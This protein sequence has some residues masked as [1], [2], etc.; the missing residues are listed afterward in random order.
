MIWIRRNISIPAM[1]TDIIN[2]SGNLTSK[3]KSAPIATGIYWFM[4]QAGKILYIG[5]SINLRHRLSSYFY[6]TPIKTEPRILKMLGMASNV[7]WK[8]FDSELLALLAEDR[9]IKQALPEYNIRQ[10]EFN[11]YCFLQLSQEDYPAL[12]IVKEPDLPGGQYFGPYRDK[13]LAEDLKQL[14]VKY[15]QFRACIEKNPAKVCVDLEI[16]LCVG[17]CIGKIQKTEYNQIKKMVANFFT[18]SSQEIVIQI[19]QRMN[20]YS[21][22]QNY[23][24]AARAKS[25]LVFCRAF[26]ERQQFLNRFK[27]DILLVTDN[28]VVPADYRFTRGNLD[29]DTIDQNVDI[30]FIH[31]RGNIVYNWIKKNSDRIQY[32]FIT[33]KNEYQ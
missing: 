2:K 11:D 15:F 31:D 25:D 7:G 8:K 23:E 20:K 5:K 24:K 26:A 13:Y 18:G 1:L 28:S 29:S 22:D 14:A 4:D 21:A 6:N 12:H 3:V 10:R 17:P 30:R 16:G 27:D 33:V 32:K 9:L 19:T